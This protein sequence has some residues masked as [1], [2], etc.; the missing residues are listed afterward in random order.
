MPKDYF[1]DINTCKMVRA[2][3]ALLIVIHHLS[4]YVYLGGPF[5]FLFEQIGNTS[6]VIFFFYSGYGLM[7]SLNAKTDYLNFFLKRRLKLV[8]VPFLIANM[9]FFVL[10]FLC[11]AIDSYIS[12]IT[13]MKIEEALIPNSWFVIMLVVMYVIFY[14]SFFMT[15]DRKSGLLLCIIFVLAIAF[16]LCAFDFGKYWYSSLFSFVFGLLYASNNVIFSNFFIN[17]KSMKILLTA[18]VFII[19][20]S[21][22]RRISN[23]YIILIIKN[24]RAILAC[25][26]VLWGSML[27]TRR[28][29]LLEYIGDISYEL[30]LYHGIVMRILSLWMSSVLLFLMTSILLSFI[31]AE[32]FHHLDNK[33]L[34]D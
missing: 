29:R 8:A 22:G 13:D 6:M 30:F 16:F 14:L 1:L 17:K 33:M 21:V 19:L 20:T 2:I 26:L 31:A 32:I 5:N 4:Q 27:I 34:R 11:G 3:M 23:D 25:M 28:Y 15:E 24:V 10:L 7:T 12:K 18:L 9:I